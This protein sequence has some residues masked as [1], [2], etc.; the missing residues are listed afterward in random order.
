MGSLT[1]LDAAIPEHVP[2]G[3]YAASAVG[4]RRPIRS[5]ATPKFPDEQYVIFPSVSWRMRRGRSLF[6]RADPVLDAGKG[7]KQDGRFYDGKSWCCN[8]CRAETVDQDRYIPAN[9]AFQTSKAIY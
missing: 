7:Y 3:G 5:E 6:V 9:H 1:A 8:Y 2:A 4:P